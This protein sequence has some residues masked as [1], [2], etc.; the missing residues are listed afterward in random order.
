MRDY[1]LGPRP[2]P[3]S[4]HGFQ[5]RSR[6]EARWAVLFDSLRIDYWYEPEGFELPDGSRYLPDFY[7]PQ[8][9]LYAEVKPDS[10]TPAE[11]DKCASLALA[12]G[13]NVLLLVGPPDFRLYDVVFI[14]DGFPTFTDAL[15]D[16]D[17]HSRKYY[18][19]ERRFFCSVGVGFSKEEDFSKDYIAA[20]YLSRGVRFEE[21]A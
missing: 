1:N 8:A 2:I 5:F 4:F 18:D 15:L 7:L 3:T 12:S 21:A 14:S 10:L 17:Y 11:M 19:E 16:I 6:L 20:V 13:R 9:R